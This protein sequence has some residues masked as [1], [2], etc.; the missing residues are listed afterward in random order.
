[1]PTIDLKSD[2]YQLIQETDDPNILQKIKD[3]FFLLKSQVEPAQPLTTE[4]KN[5][6]KQGLHEIETGD[7]LTNAEVRKEINQWIKERQ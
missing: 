4:E 3:L 7:V 2:L 5:L 1:M 6:M